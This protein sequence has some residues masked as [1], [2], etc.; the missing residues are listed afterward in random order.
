MREIRKKGWR[1][2]IIIKKK[3]NEM[4]II[5]YITFICNVQHHLKD[6]NNP[7]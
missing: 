3:I 4:L 6:K 1:N 2:G 7:W 5:T